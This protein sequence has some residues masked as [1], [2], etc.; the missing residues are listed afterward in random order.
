MFDLGL[1]ELLIILIV[2]LF[3]MGP[4]DFPKVV[5][6]LA[7]FTRQLGEFFTEAKKHLDDDGKK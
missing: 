5:R 4:E 7:R 3:V 6:G 1:V 2:A